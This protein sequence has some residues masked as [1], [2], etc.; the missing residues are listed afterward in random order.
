MNLSDI[1]KRRGFH[2]VRRTSTGGKQVALGFP[3]LHRC[4]C[5]SSPL[6]SLPFP[7]ILLRNKLRGLHNPPYRFVCPSFASGATLALIH[8][9][10]G[11]RCIER[12]RELL[13]SNT[14]RI[15][16]LLFLACY[17]RRLGERLSFAQPRRESWKFSRKTLSFLSFVDL[18]RDAKS[19]TLSVLIGFINGKG[20]E[21]G[22]SERG[23]DASYRPRKAQTAI[24]R[25]KS[26]KR[27]LVTR[28]FN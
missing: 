3:C 5:V 21:L 26:R 22:N 1:R 28:Q 27:H 16:V 6:F 11:A 13:I 17:Q 23:I 7:C 19:L 15:S 25:Q 18:P 12:E 20:W 14:S 2:Y 9:P 24:F 4:K 8:F 10:A